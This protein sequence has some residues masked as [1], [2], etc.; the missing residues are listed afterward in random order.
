M[1]NFP[2][3]NT[4]TYFDFSVIPTYIINLKNRTDRKDHVLKQFINHE[5]F[6]LTIVEGFSHSFGSLGLWMTIRHI[7]QDL[8]SDNED[9][10]IIGEDDIEFTN[11]YS[12]ESLFHNINE[13]AKR[14]ADVLL[15]GISWFTEGIQITN[16][17]FWI[18]N[19][20][21]L[22]FTVIFKSFFKTLLNTRLKDYDAADYHFS[23]LS[24]NIFV[25]FPFI[26]IQKDFGYSDATEKNNAVGRIQSIFTQTSKRLEI[27]DS[28][29]TVFLNAETDAKYIEDLNFDELTMPTYII[30][31]P[32][33]TERLEHIKRQ[34][35]NRPE[36]DI[37]IIPAYKN[38]VGAL[39]L[40][41]TI[42]KIIKMALEN[43]DDV[44][45]ISE[46]DHE[47][48]EYYSRDL[49]LQNIFEAHQEG[50]SFLSGGTGKF[51]DAI[52]LT[53]D[54]YWIKHCLSTQ[55][56]VVFKK[57]YQQILDEPFD[58]TIVADL[59]YS[60]MA[61]NKMVLY[62][63]ISIQK[64]FGYSDITALHNENKGIVGALF[65]ES[66]LKLTDI[67]NAYTRFY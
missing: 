24:K 62:P 5:E 60:R 32:E 6:K 23:L 20:S 7:I 27:L 9:F 52:P 10:I 67:R 22:H 50:A 54:R 8:I 38:E 56:I 59:A 14:K 49:L 39:G 47:F 48:T 2:I 41:L 12:K 36:F 66:S 21:G 30:N 18:Q 53:K 28:V 42:R 61:S 1:N 45:I 58:N 34:F 43:D 15:G 63:F 4:E 51:N 57:F 64:E 65:T 25:V 46:D 29:K 13:A 26:A 44:I 55:F 35:A 3:E 40:W 11:C 37:K 19:F 16:N 33:R 31:L 17:L